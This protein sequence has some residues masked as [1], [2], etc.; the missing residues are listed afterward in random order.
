MDVL[1]PFIFSSEKNGISSPPPA[2]EDPIYT[3]TKIV[4]DK[5]S[6]VLRKEDKK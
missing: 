1:R 3:I 4:M 5:T 2:F 6:L